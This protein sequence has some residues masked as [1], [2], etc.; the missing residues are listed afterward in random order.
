MAN[1]LNETAIEELLVGNA[2]ISNMTG[3]KIDVKDIGN[4]KD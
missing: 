3:F 1:F 4:L 2:D